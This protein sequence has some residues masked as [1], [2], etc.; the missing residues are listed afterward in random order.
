MYRQIKATPHLE[1][2]AMFQLQSERTVYQHNLQL[3]GRVTVI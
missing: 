3:F 2:D 1:K